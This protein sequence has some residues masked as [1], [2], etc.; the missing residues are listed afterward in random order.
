MQDVVR[1]CSR[2]CAARARRANRVLDA[3]TRAARIMARMR[4]RWH[5]RR[6]LAAS[7][8]ASSRVVAVAAAANA[9]LDTLDGLVVAPG[10]PP[11]VCPAP[12]NASGAAGVGMGR[13]TQGVPLVG[14]AVGAFSAVPEVALHG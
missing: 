5:G 11:S 12:L 2:L 14:A 1:G 13:A 9:P 3:G 8:L 4:M 10:A 7:R 6:A